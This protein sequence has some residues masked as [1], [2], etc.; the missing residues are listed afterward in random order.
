MVAETDM[1]ASPPKRTMLQLIISLMTGALLSKIL[2]FVREIAM[3]LVIG[4]A[5]VADAFRTSITIILLPIA[6]LQSET[7]P[8]ILIPMQQEAIRRG[9][10][11]L[12]LAALT[13]V[14]VLITVVLMLAL[15]VAGY[16]LVDWV[17]AGFS[18]EEKTLTFRFVQIMALAMPASV[19]LNVLS[20]GEIALGRGRISNARAA[21]QN[22]SILIGIAG[23][24]L[25]G[26]VIL[27]AWAFSLS[28]NGVAL[29][30][31][32]L[33]IR[34]GHLSFRGLSPRH[35]L[36]SAGNFFYRLR[37]FLALPVVEQAAIWVE[38]FYTSR[39]QVGAIASLDYARTLTE[40]FQLLISQPVG[41]AVLAHADR[42]RQEEQAK[43]IARIV[44]AF[45]MPACAFIFVFAEEIV[46]VVFKRGAFGETGLFL[47]SQAL[48]GISIGLWASTLGWILLRL[49]N[50]A[51]RNMRVALILMVS[52]AAGTAFNVLASGRA[53]VDGSDIV[54]IGLGET[55][56]ALV[57]LAGVLFSMQKGYRLLPIIGLAALP[58]V[59]MFVL[60]ALVEDM[61]PGVLLRLAIGLSALGL[62]L[63]IAIAILVPGA[64]Q[65]SFAA[66]RR[67]LAKPA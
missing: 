17:V 29:W 15:Q 63:A 37:P 41:L 51:N 16:L 21:F 6:F 53:P 62:C 19:A 12:S 59:L 8:A 18:V 46:S 56:R 57:M 49:L 3:A 54:L 47:T 38:R 11:A 33:L 10:G 1:V 55:T 60:G 14:L 25:G 23:V 22:L 50:S 30:A 34:E 44:L 24:A 32:L 42:D 36:R 66:A 45:A 4:T 27:L 52:Y 64:Y 28:F 61:V 65:A 13:S 35:V 48:K 67:R 26:D 31:C 5:V 2:G 43:L 9:R 20:A 58:A 39:L 40:S 7:V